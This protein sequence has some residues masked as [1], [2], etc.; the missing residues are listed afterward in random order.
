[1]DMLPSKN[2]MAK[3]IYQ[4]TSQNHYIGQAHHFRIFANVRS[5]YAIERYVNETK[6]LY[7]VLD[8]RLKASP[9]LAGDKYT[10]ADIAHFACVNAAPTALEIDISEWPALNGWVERIK[11]RDA[12]KNGLGVPRGGMGVEEIAGRMKNGR[13]RIDAM[14]NTDRY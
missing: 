6:R 11:Q 7:S 12:V 13:A 5:D 10:I 3:I 1:M 4:L 2:S 8:S 9:Y 14:T